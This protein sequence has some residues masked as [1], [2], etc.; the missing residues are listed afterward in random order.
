M[1]NKG[2]NY[3]LWMLILC[4]VFALIF[5]PLSLGIGLFRFGGK[6]NFLLLFWGYASVALITKWLTDIFLYLNNSG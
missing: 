5:K 2:K 1:L 4:L 6:E 3:Y